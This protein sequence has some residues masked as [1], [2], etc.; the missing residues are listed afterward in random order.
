MH[1]DERDLLEALIFEEI[2]E[3][4]GTWLRAII[5]R[6]EKEQGSIRRGQQKQPT[7]GYQTLRGIPLY[8]KHHTKSAKS[9]CPT[10]LSRRRQVLVR[11]E[12]LTRGQRRMLLPLP[13]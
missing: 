10:A 7:S 8:Q 1:E 5:Q 13:R 6:L 4:A 2:E 9:A 12:L 11:F 3:T